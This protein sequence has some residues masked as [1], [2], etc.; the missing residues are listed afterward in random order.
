MY[1]R[2]ISIKGFKS[3]AKKVELNFDPGIIM[4][5]GPNG[6]GKSN[7]T[8][9]IQWVLG[10]QS[11]S[12]L[13]GGSM[14]DVIFAG[15]LNQKPRSLAEVSLTLDNSNKKINLDF[16]E[17]TITRKL[18]KDGDNLY[19]INST[20]CRLLDIYELL[21]DTQL[22]RQAH[23]IIGQGK[24]E[25]IISSKPDEKRMLLEEAAGVLKHKKR[26]ERSLRRLI[27]TSDNLNRAKD[28]LREVNKQIKPLKHQVGKAKTKKDLQKELEELEIALL[29]NKISGVKSRW[30]NINEKET[31]AKKR[32]SPLRDGLKILSIDIEHLED[33]NANK[34]KY[35]AQKQN[36]KERLQSAYNGFKTVFS[37]A[38][39]KELTLSN[40]IEELA[41]QF[42][43]F[44][45]RLNIKTAQELN[46]KKQLED[47]K[48]NIN[49]NLKAIAS[50]RKESESLVPKYSDLENQ[51]Q[52]KT[53]KLE[54]LDSK[55]KSIESKK[56][57]NENDITFLKKQIEKQRNEIEKLILDV[58]K[59]TIDANTLEEKLS[60]Q[61]NNIIEEQ[62]A[63]SQLTEDNEKQIQKQSD[64]EKLLAGALSKK[65]KIKSNLE[66]LENLGK[67]L[68]LKDIFKNSNTQI[69]TQ[70]LAKNLH[71][72]NKYVKAI[73]AY[74]GSLAQGLLV[75]NLN[76]A[77]EAL[78]FAKESNQNISTIIMQEREEKSFFLD[79]VFKRK[80]PT[81][82]KHLFSKVKI[83]DSLDGIPKSANDITY[84]TLSG[85]VY[86]KGT[87]RADYSK[88]KKSLLSINKEI[89]E[90]KKDLSIINSEI[91]S[92]NSEKDLL[93]NSISKINSNIYEKRKSI[94]KAKELCAGTQAELKFLS[95]IKDKTKQLK[96]DK[97]KSISATT[98]KIKQL[99]ME[100]N[101]IEDQLIVLTKEKIESSKEF[102]AIKEE[103]E[104]S[105]KIKHSF[106]L[107]LTELNYAA[108]NLNQN[109]L[110]LEK[111]RKEQ[112]N[113]NVELNK[114][115]RYCLKKM[116]NSEKYHSD[117]SKF[118]PIL[119]KLLDISLEIS[120]KQKQV[121]LSDK[122]IDKL[123]ALREKQRNLVQETKQIEE[124][125]H[126]QEIDKSALKSKLDE[127]TDRIIQDHATSVEEAINKYGSLEADKNRIQEIKDVLEK[128]GPV[129]DVAEEQ[130]HTLKERREFMEKQIEDLYK[131]K[132]SINKIIRAIDKKM[133]D[134]MLSAFEAVSANFKEIYAKLF[135][136]GHAE[137]ILTGDNIFDSGLEVKAQP[138]GKKLKKASLLSGGETALTALALLFAV[139]HTS[140]SPFYVLDEV[141]AA[142]DDINLQRFIHLLKEMKR[143]TQF[144]VITHQRRTMEVADCIY[145]VTMQADGV[146]KVISQNITDSI[147]DKS[148]AEPKISIS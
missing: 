19:F 26:K 148:I 18:T 110:S 50:K 38:Q 35:L 145:G 105:L 97:E 20:P 114:Q 113:E 95:Q 101:D 71:V 131:S 100:Q 14:K 27:S 72:K 28:I 104:E 109:Q 51:K 62:K 5:V 46:T 126:K 121:V 73:E 144:I 44:E 65:T 25:E 59:K 55:I 9:A 60:N 77:K 34:A 135:P 66:F 42:K 12:A 122:F 118:I 2:S 64:N 81:G 3:F 143:E 1:L 138:Y 53:K 141:E 117:I 21:H 124:Q 90:D 103:L 76:D 98:I 112:N 41:E 8:D 139:Y 32:L 84:I 116:A 48:T 127:L 134:K 54:E 23:S 74:L 102:D 13:R 82:I 45:S 137:L 24:I 69:S 40:N 88:N 56:L 107:A 22:G 6:S 10:E 86:Y 75:A 49:R 130:F 147:E 61:R 79:N 33:E 108:K 129:N 4:I 91:E 83:T 106:S 31:L 36:A 128:I 123:K 140:P 119:K 132:V 120:N 7:I 89:R 39:Q 142:L 70:L 99:E 58:S 93:I 43:S 96:E 80:I 94:N 29:V 125:N 136:G 85:E 115:K 78:R 47:V 92:L 11:P 68:S 15:S 37:L 16:S 111:Q 87:L 133:K 63:L 30:E 67:K 52:E 17:I 146:S 57:G